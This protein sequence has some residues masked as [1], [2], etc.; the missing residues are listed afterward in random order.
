[1]LLITQIKTSFKK[2]FIIYQSTMSGQSCPSALARVLAKRMANS[3]V[4][5]EKHLR[6]ELFAKMWMTLRKPTG[7]GEVL[8]SSS[9]RKLFFKEKRRENCANGVMSVLEPWKRGHQA[10]AVTV[11]ECGHCK[12]MARQ[13][14]SGDKCLDFSIF[15]SSNLL[16]VLPVGR[17][18]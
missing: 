10:E 8:G 14:R 11:E 4:S 5:N 15:L 16:P 13:G 1:M 17:T 7:D 12:T 18:Q 6:K 3:K 9:A 2:P